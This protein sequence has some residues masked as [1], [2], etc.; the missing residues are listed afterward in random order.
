M[1]PLHGSP[2]SLDTQEP[3]S[4]LPRLDAPKAYPG[5]L[6]IFREAPFALYGLVGV[7]VLLFFAVNNAAVPA[8]NRPV[9]QNIRT[10]L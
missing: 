4:Q 8:A 1:M 2:L 7:G 10:V 3:G 6:E 9:G 5:A